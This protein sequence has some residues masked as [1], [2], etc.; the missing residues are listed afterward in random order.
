M[1]PRIPILE[2]SHDDSKL[3]N[4]EIYITLTVPVDTN[5]FNEM[6]EH[7]ITTG[8]ISSQYNGSF[9][10]LVDGI[11]MMVHDHPLADQD[12]FFA[13]IIYPEQQS[14]RIISEG[15]TPLLNQAFDM[16]PEDLPGCFTRWSNLI[17]AYAECRLLVTV[18][19]RNMTISMSFYPVQHE[20]PAL[21][22]VGKYYL[23]KQNSQ[24]FL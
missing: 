6:L 22:R 14:E 18:T 20:R 5:H 16:N 19:S 10:P 13:A 17:R 3:L 11:W 7:R 21:V 8:R 23:S 1:P 24:Q 4:A 9:N 15:I 2:V 12:R